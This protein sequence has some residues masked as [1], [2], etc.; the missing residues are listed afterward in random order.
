MGVLGFAEIIANLELK[1][2]REVFTDEGRE[3]LPADPNSRTRRLETGAPGFGRW[4]QLG[5]FRAARRALAA[6]ASYTV[7]K[8]VAL[9]AADSA[10]AKGPSRGSPDRKRPIMPPRRLPL[11]PC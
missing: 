1:G 11:S 7:E 5:C 3:L 2:E 10:L 9:N 4:V 6:F 8:R